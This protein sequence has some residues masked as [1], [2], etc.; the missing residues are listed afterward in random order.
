MHFTDR[1]Q[2][3]FAPLLQ[4]CKPGLTG[5]AGCHIQGRSTLIPLKFHYYE[6]ADCIEIM[7]AF[8][9]LTMRCPNK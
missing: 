5:L 1:T 6:K 3:Q 2:A 9:K 8:K 4:V 7:I